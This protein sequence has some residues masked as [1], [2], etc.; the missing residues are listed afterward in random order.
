M[1]LSGTNWLESVIVLLL[2]WPATYLVRKIVIILLEH[3]SKKTAT[4]IDDILIESL[5]PHLN[6]WVVLL[7]VYLALY[8]SFANQ[9]N[10]SLLTKII[11]TIFLVSVVWLTARIAQRITQTYGNRLALSLPL[12]SLSE[13]IIRL[14]ILIIGGLII[15]SHLGIAITPILTALGVGSLAV[16][17]ALQDT[18][19][20]LFAGFHILA[21]HQIRPGDY[22]K[23]DS[24]P[25]GY[26]LD[27]GWRSTRI[28]ELPDNVII[29]PNARLAQSILLN[30]YQPEKEMSIVISVGVSYDSNLELVEKITRETAIHI[31]KNIPGA[32]PD[33]EPLIRYHTFGDSSINFSVVLRVKEYS[34]QYLVKHEFIKLLHQQYRQH[35]III[36][37]PQRDVHIIQQKV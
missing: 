30:F 28:R 5:K 37:Y 4:Q 16:A 25:E 23:L 26:I 22:I 6:I 13:Q 20:N 14:T 1:S 36:P 2:I 34:N 12:T 29:I 17:L 33:F 11:T 15:L 32:V 7:G 21:S 18:L 8:L 19:S 9:P 10:F 35:N 24:G 3:W 27:I 31:Q